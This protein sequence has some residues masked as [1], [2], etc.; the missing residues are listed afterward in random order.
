M[1]ENEETGGKENVQ[2]VGIEKEVIEIV[3]ERG[4]VVG[5]MSMSPQS[6]MTQLTD[7]DDRRRDRDR[8]RSP[9]SRRRV[10]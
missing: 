6:I 10:L 2:I 5:S 8:S 7:S 9:A 1:I 4:R 3:E